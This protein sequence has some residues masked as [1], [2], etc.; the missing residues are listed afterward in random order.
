MQRLDGEQ[1]LQGGAQ[2]LGGLE[3]QMLG[4][5]GRG[6][7]DRPVPRHGEEKTE[8]LDAP[9]TGDGLAI[10]RGFAVDGKARGLA[11]GGPRNV[12]TVTQDFLHR[13]GAVRGSA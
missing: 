5:V 7:R 4:K 1:P 12:L 3:S 2:H 6:M 9:E 11:K 8:R 13:M 10:A